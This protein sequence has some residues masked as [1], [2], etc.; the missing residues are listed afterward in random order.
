MLEDEKYSH[1]AI[2]DIAD[3]Y[4]RIY[5]H[6]LENALMAATTRSNHVHAIMRLLSGWNGTE[7]FGIPVGN[8]PSR[9]LAEAV[10]ID[11]D[12]A[13]LAAGVEF[14]R[15]NDD[16]RILAG[17][18]GEAYRRLASL[19]DVLYRNHG[20]TLQPQ[21]TTVVSRNE[22]I[23]RSQESPEER[24]LDSLYARFQQ[25]ID[26][27]GLS[28]WYEE[29]GYADLTGAQ[30]ALVDSL[31]LQAGLHE[32]L[33]SKGIRCWL[34]QKQLLPG[35]DVSRELERGIHL[36]DK[37]LLCAS[38]NS[39]TSW[40]VED[41]IKTTLEKERTLRREREKPVRKLIPLDL[42]G[43]MFTDQWDLG[44]LANEIRSR[45]AANFQ[46][47]ETNRQN[48]DIQV[49]RVIKALRADEGARELPPPSKL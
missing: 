12:E 3:F 44:V 21:K 40:W 6:R 17:S 8:Q 7:S 42:D 43:Y 45:V 28:G 9:L 5:L 20:L 34:D 4:P 32:A 22:Y 38:K 25:L 47:W 36:W 49:D 10:L 31:N 19:A 2:A 18:H 23:I 39:L 16:Y 26:D 30:Q 33:Q 37:F 41:E 29:I 11:V 27:L 1:V 48:F 35:D 15:F 14:V 46:G 13:M 24:E